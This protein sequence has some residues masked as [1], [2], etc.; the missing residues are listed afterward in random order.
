M[1]KILLMLAAAMFIAV[2]CDSLGG[3]GNQTGEGT[4][5][6][7]DDPDD[8]DN[9][10]GNIDDTTPL[11]PEENR[12]KLEQIGLKAISMAS[13]DK[14]VDLLHVIDEFYKLVDQYPFEFIYEMEDP[15]YRKI[16]PVDPIS[17]L[18]SPVRA[19][20][21]SGSPYMLSK[22]V[23]E[24]SYFYEAPR[25]YGIYEFDGTGKEWKR[26]DS[27]D[28]LSFIFPY[29]GQ[30]VE[31]VVSASGQEYSY[32]FDDEYSYSDE[33]Y[34]G[35]GNWVSEE[36]HYIDHIT[37]TVPAHIEA[38]VKLGG[39]DLL[40][41][42]VDGEYNVGNGP[43]KQTFSLTAGS[44]DVDMNLE[45]TDSRVSQA[46]SFD[47][48]GT[49][50]LS[51]EVS[52]EGSHLC[53]V[54]YYQDNVQNMFEGAEAHVSVLDLNVDA[55]C[56]DI[57]TFVNDYLEMDEAAYDWDDPDVLESE[58]KLP[59]TWATE[60]YV[61]DLCDMINSTFTVEASYGSAEPFADFIAKPMFSNEIYYYDR[62]YYESEWGDGY[63]TGQSGE[64]S[65]YET[66]YVIKFKNDGAEYEIVNFF[67]ETDYASVVDAAEDLADRY[68]F[69]LNYMFNN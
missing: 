45:I 23:I 46:F 5:E 63:Q 3:F 34:D 57:S 48:D 19:F 35:N 11:T 56:T 37:I 21:E 60:D 25:A 36:E 61:N 2:A 22:A 17:A 69:Y 68:E 38:S 8:P 55:R 1:K 12:E 42:E 44:Y 14:Q 30:T 43:V 20:C 18:L 24:D 49:R 67:N 41:I 15:S 28:R 10:G 31:A 39:R 4:T 65:G 9:P 62:Y 26:K 54:D 6:N 47:I 64:C 13:P 52:G 40:A 50:L 29:D 7:P 66:T 33:Y 58:D 27:D 53:D 16:S 51:T 59:P 32:E